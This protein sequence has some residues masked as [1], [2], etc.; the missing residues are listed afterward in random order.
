MNWDYCDVENIKDKEEVLLGYEDRMIR[1]AKDKELMSWKENDVY[2]E[3][4]DKGQKAITS[5]WVVTEKIKGDKK[6]CKARL[7]ARGFEEEMKE[8]EKDAPTCTAETLKLCL[9]IMGSKEWKCHTLD[10]KTAYLQGDNIEREVYVRPPKGENNGVLWRL[11]KTVYGL[12]DAAKAWYLKVV[13]VVEELGGKKCTLEPKVFYWKQRDEFVG[14]LCTHVDDFC[15]GGTEEFMK[16][17]IGKMKEKLKVGEE[18]LG[19]FKYIGVMVRQDDRGIVLDQM[20]YLETVVEPEGRMYQGVRVLKEREL[21][22]YRSVTGQLNWVALHTMPELAYDVSDLSK[23]FKEGTT[24]DMR[25]L[26]RVV[27]KAKRSS[28]KVRLEKIEGKKA[29]W[30]VYADASFGN[31]EEGQTQIGFVVALTDGKKRCPIWWKSRKARRVAKS[32]IE[33]EALSAGEAMEGAIYFNKL[34]E[35]IVGG[36][37]LD[38]MVKTDSKTLMKAVKSSTGVSSKRLKIDIAAMREAME[39]GEV[40]EVEWIPKEQQVAD[41]LTKQGVSGE[42]I[43][44]YVGGDRNRQ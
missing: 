7:V 44:E 41:L 24:Q 37:K 21:T 29:H 10:V 14:I 26:I 22:E 25:R 23:G 3:V 8:W 20:K 35:E 39:K 5:K 33:A 34:W 19:N 36:R 43:R 30:E 40:S 9:S 12:K 4:E 16:E 27:R 38:I 6:V 32:T 1:E 11:K 2:E 42:L 17:V 15:F 13:K 28:P 31:V 18:E